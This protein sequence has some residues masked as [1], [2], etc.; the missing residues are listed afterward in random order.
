M[1]ITYNKQGERIIYDGEALEYE[2]MDCGHRFE[3][4]IDY[5][6]CCPNEPMRKGILEE[7]PTICPEC[8]SRNVERI[9]NKKHTEFME[10]VKGR[11][12]YE[13]ED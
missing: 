6:C 13:W 4:L 10:I 11:K 1:F 8:N 3:R 9:R 12:L 5:G 7:H 2:C